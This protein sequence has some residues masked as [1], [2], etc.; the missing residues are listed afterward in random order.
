[1]ILTEQ[2]KKDFIEWYSK[3]VPH[4]PLSGFRGNF[5]SLSDSMK[6]GVLVDF[7]TS[8][9]IYITIIN[10]IDFIG[11]QINYRD[12]NDYKSKTLH[13]ART[14]AIEKANEIYNNDTKRKS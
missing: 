12:Y 11:V 5:Y 6:Y 2:C 1:M 7:F 10:E 14:K 8:E 9:E 13:E 4:I 3:N